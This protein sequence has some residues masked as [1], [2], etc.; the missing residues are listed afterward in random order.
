[1][2]KT[3]LRST[4]LIFFL[5][6]SSGLYAQAG[7]CFVAYGAATPLNPNLVPGP[8]GNFYVCPN[9]PVTFT[10]NQG[11]GNG[12]INLNNVKSTLNNA[13]PN[14]SYTIQN[15]PYSPLPFT[16]GTLPTWP[17]NGGGTTAP[18]DNCSDLVNIGFPFCFFNETFTQVRIGS[19]G[20]IT[21]E[22]SNNCPIWATGNGPFPNASYPRPAVM[23][24]FTDFLPGAPNA[25]SFIR[26]R[27]EG[28]A[29][30][31]R[32]VLTFRNVPYF[33]CTTL[34]FTGQLVLYEATRVIETFIQSK[35]TCAGWNSGRSTHG[36]HRSNGANAVVV[37]GRNNVAWAVN[38]PEGKRFVPNGSLN[39]NPV[40]FWYQLLPGNVLQPVGTGT[41]YTLTPV[42][43]T[44]VLIVAPS[45]STQNLCGIPGGQFPFG[46][47]T[48]TV[49][50][51]PPNLPPIQVTNNLCFGASTGQAVTTGVGMPAFH[52]EWSILNGSSIRDTT[53]QQSTDTLRNLSNGDYFV[54][55]TDGNGCTAT[56]QFTVVGPSAPVELTQDSI[57]D[58]KC[59]GVST[60][61]VY[62]HATGGN[63]GYT[64]TELA[65]GQSNSN[66]A[67]TNLAAGT[68]SIV[69]TDQNLCSDTITFT[70][71]Q[72]DTLWYIPDSLRNVYCH[73][74][75]TGYLQYHGIGGSPP[76]TYS[77]T[78]TSITPPANGLGV[79][80][81][82]PWGIYTATVTDFNQC[83]ISFDTTLTQPA[84][85]L[86]GFVN[87]TTNVACFGD[88]TG[89]V[90]VTPQGGTPPYSLTNGLITIFSP[91]GNPV[92]FSNLGVGVD[93]ILIVDTLGCQFY[94]P[95]QISGPTQAL[96]VSITNI[97]N[98]L[99]LPTIN[100]SVTALA[101]GGTSL[102]G[103]YTY[104]LYSLPLAGPPSLLSTNITGVFGGLGGGN[105]Q[106]VVTDNNGCTASVNFSLTQPTA[107]LS[108]NL[109]S[110]TNILCYGAATGA[111]QITSVGGT[112]PYRYFLNGVQQTSN[113]MA[114]LTAGVY[115]LSITDTNGCQ[116]TLNVTLTQPAVA[117]SGSVVSSTNPTCFGVCNGGFQLTATGGTSPY[118][119]SNGISSNPTGQ[120][121]NQCAGLISA[122]VTD[123]NGCSFPIPLTLT[124]PA[125]A[126]SGSIVQ[127][128]PVS[129]FG[130]SNGGVTVLASGGTA[131]YTYSIACSTPPQQNITGVFSG[132]PPGNCPVLIT[133]Q[134][135][136]TY[137]QPVIITQPAAPVSVS[138][139]G[140]VPVDC[141]GN[142][143]GSFC[144][145]TSGG[146]GPYAIVATETTTF[147]P[148]GVW[149]PTTTCFE[150]VLAG[151]YAIV[152]TD[153]A[154]CTTT[155]NVSISQPAAPLSATAQ[156]QAVLC[157]GEQTGSI[158]VNP[159]GG[160]APYSYQIS[161]PGSIFVATN[162]F[163]N[164]AAGNYTVVVKDLNNCTF[165]VGATVSQPA[166]AVSSVISNQVNQTCHGG[167]SGCVTVSAV[168]GTGTAPYTYTYQGVSTTTGV[169][170]NLS[171]GTFN[172]V[173]TDANQ[174]AY[175]QLVNITEP[176]PVQALINSVVPV[177]CFNGSDG[178][179]TASATGGTP[180][181][182]TPYTYQWVN[183]L[184]TTPLATN[185]VA[186]TYCVVVTDGN[187]CTS[188]TCATVSEP[189][190]LIINAPPLSFICLGDSATLFGAANGGT[191]PYSFSWLPN[192]VS[193]GITGTP[194]KVA[195]V[196]STNYLIHVTDSRGCQSA[197]D[198]SRVVV[199]SIPTP[200]FSVPNQEGCE[201]FCT[202]FQDLSIIASAVPDSIVWWRWEFG[203]EQISDQSNPMH[204]Y[205]A[206]GRYDVKLTVKSAYGCKTS[207]TQN[208]IVVVH[209]KPY[210]DFTFGPQPT[211]L[212]DSKIQFSAVELDSTYYK[213]TFGDGNTSVLHQP[214][215][216][217]G[218]TGNYCV[219][220]KMTTN[221]GC[222]DSL[223]RCLRIS[224]NFTL[225]APNSFSPNR[226]GT[227][228]EFLL[229][230][231]YIREY[232]LTI[233]NRWGTV[234]FET[235][236]IEKGWDG[237]FNGES[238]PEG[239]YSWY[240]KAT[241]TE[242]LSYRKNGMISLIR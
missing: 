76:Y 227:N 95:F 225:F 230:G 224:P 74:D 176:P 226:D 220:L 116:A 168:A 44:T 206:D 34:Q 123:N 127:Q 36:I 39:C 55:V 66:G 221:Y 111:I 171:A 69:A 128:I 46:A 80:D 51:S 24:P 17:T 67:F 53:R 236:D 218:D 167:S 48:I 103:N 138:V 104:R 2:V 11:V 16:T 195:P 241:D 207:L 205:E 192:G 85:P 64:Y 125:S 96:T 13:N 135:G 148:A 150:Q 181:P 32:F 209:P 112:N 157:T 49:I 198:T 183:M 115:Q 87:N 141:F 68:F 193:A 231:Q 215:H 38:T 239:T 164:L 62:V 233:Y 212:L 97:Q 143:T 93:S 28:V 132:L 110:Q 109:L 153:A 200:L 98:V 235:N 3:L 151:T 9:V 242:G 78:S 117:L 194:V 170:C 189:D 41:N 208:Q 178:S 90:S 202:Q 213:W 60:G 23:F 154:G 10:F 191:P 158:V 137:T 72:P 139:I 238:V 4:F 79:F 86:S 210:P 84:T 81:N 129:C 174:C 91:G 105:Y 201:T 113:L 63:P 214:M 188:Q 228:E 6:K 179:A 216:E 147:L 58:L 47:D 203:D 142:A 122:L 65:S 22:P 199:N 173:V 126:L 71:T 56:G 88:T 159:T 134:N 12:S 146:T 43:D 152:V 29:P 35:P 20:Y 5:L 184:N 114:N 121:S 101:A 59:H 37:P 83:S 15:I 70:L 19:N 31:R 130:G 180:G 118:T 240:V 120:F 1:M 223:I 21:F 18:D 131:T 172:I 133:D 100:G 222:A 27:T 99:C 175:I 119:Y 232:N 217:Y 166:L 190:T 92:L 26:Y 160:T 61:R 108:V 57:F 155:G 204:C 145:Q 234:V 77:I 136:C 25:N 73:G 140:S 45:C 107:P 229:K 177:S 102:N 182:V 124:E 162:Q 211:T 33:S 52:Y 163:D 186:G 7:N 197:V 89:S 161:L 144:L 187:N 237:T 219:Q 54:L 30:C 165:T 82:L 42:Q 94:V 106:I 156:T 185:L 50:L 196:T 149:N 75:Y 169:F 14:Q 8:G 40:T